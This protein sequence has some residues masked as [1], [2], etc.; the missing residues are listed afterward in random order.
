MSPRKCSSILE[1][2]KVRII[3]EEEGAV[4]QMINDVNSVCAVCPGPN[5]FQNSKVLAKGL[6]NKLSH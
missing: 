2:V 4:K 3:I 5:S 6:S 1:C